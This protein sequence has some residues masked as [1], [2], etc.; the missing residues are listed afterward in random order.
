MSSIDEG[1]AGCA[2]FGDILNCN[3]KSDDQ[4]DE[5]FCPC[6]DCLIK[7]ICMESCEDYCALADFTKR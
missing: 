1:C 2:V 5:K 6:K 7:G 4:F 3:Y